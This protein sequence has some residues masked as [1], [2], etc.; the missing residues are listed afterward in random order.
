MDR[1]ADLPPTSYDCTSSANITPLS[2]FHKLIKA[3]NPS[4]ARGPDCIP[5][6]VLKEYADILAGSISNVLN[7]SYRQQKLPSVWKRRML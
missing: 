1:D 7:T 3:L 4:K 5:T 2:T 6:W